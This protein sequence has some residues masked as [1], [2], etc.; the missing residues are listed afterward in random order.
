MSPSHLPFPFLPKTAPSIL[1]PL[2]SYFCWTQGVWF[3]SPMPFL[4]SPSFLIAMSWGVSFPLQASWSCYCCFYG[5]FKRVI[6]DRF[7]PSTVGWSFAVGSVS[8]SNFPLAK[9]WFDKSKSFWWI[10]ISLSNWPY[11]KVPS[12]SCGFLWS[13]TSAPFTRPTFPGCAFW[14][15][16]FAINN[17]Q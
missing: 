17:Q 2:H 11:R 8:A 7:F 10:V 9:F 1:L 5:S 12:F 3:I 4:T 16:R 13:S 14:E 6:W 15:I